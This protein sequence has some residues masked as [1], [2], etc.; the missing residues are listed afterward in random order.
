VKGAS[1]YLTPGPLA[2][3]YAKQTVE[4]LVKNFPASA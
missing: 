2:E 4:W 3:A 1:H